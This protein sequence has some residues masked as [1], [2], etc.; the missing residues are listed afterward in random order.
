VHHIPHGYVICRFRQEYRFERK[1]AEEGKG[2]QNFSSM[3][4]KTHRIHRVV[5]LHKDIQQTFVE[6]DDALCSISPSHKDYSSLT[7]TTTTTTTNDVCRDMD[8]DTHKKVSSTCCYASSQDF[9]DND[10][11][12]SGQITWY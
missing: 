12:W 11:F 2:S 1:R 3:A 7:C 4:S 8:H 6:P 9:F 5:V 10:N